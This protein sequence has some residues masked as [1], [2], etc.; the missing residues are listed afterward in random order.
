MASR[1]RCAAVRH[2]PSNARCVRERAR[3]S[4]GG[5]SLACLR[6]TMPSSAKAR[7]CSSRPG[8]AA[9]EGVSNIFSGSLSAFARFQMSFGPNPVLQSSDARGKRCSRGF[10]VGVQRS[11]DPTCIALPH[12][13]SA[14]AGVCNQTAT[15][16]ARKIEQA[17]R[18]VCGLCAP[19]PAQIAGPS[20]SPTRQRDPGYQ[21]TPRV[22]PIISQI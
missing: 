10:C 13:A 12:K 9:G 20:L 19:A 22:M 14:P 3:S 21:R 1:P 18:R 15:K 5:D 2:Q 4:A 6:C 11:N 17:I 7:R 16:P 8:F